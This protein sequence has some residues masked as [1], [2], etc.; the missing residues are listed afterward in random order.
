MDNVEWNDLNG[1]V[2]EWCQGYFTRD[3]RLIPKDGSPCVI[4]SADRILRGGCHHNGDIHCRVNNRYEI[5]PASKDEC[6][7]FRIVL[8]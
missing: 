5:P 4:E 1:N 6:I 2:W 3:T 8:S 7:G